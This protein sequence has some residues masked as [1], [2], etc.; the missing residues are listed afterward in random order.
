MFVHGVVSPPFLL[1]FLHQ[2]TRLLDWVPMISMTRWTMTLG[3]PH[4]YSMSS[5]Y[6]TQGQ[7]RVHSPLPALNPLFSQNR[8]ESSDSGKCQ[9]VPFV[10]P[11][12]YKI[13]RHRVVWLLGNWVGVK[14]SP[15]LRPSLYSVLTQVLQPSEDL[16]VS[17]Y[18]SHG[19][20]QVAPV[21]SCRQPCG[22]SSLM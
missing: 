12:R 19:D 8:G 5:E 16:V 22:S 14:M 1:F 2:S 13:V 3:T 11:Y 4:S 21:P 17:V 6:K 7:S 15:S 18:R 10:T 20:S 9:P